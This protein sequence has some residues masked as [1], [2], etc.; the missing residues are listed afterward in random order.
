MPEYK[1]PRL[2][3]NSPDFNWTALDQ[4]NQD[5]VKDTTRFYEEKK[6]NR[7]EEIGQDFR[8]SIEAGIMQEYMK[9]RDRG[10][11]RDLGEM[12]DYYKGR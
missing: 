4:Y 11:D 9:D 12:M 6:K 7:E 2:D 10:Y 1:D 5:V 3:P 8:N